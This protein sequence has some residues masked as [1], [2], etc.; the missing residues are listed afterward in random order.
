MFFDLLV[1]LEE[2]ELPYFEAEMLHRGQLCMAF[3]SRRIREI[4]EDGK[5]F[6][7]PSDAKKYFTKILSH[8]VAK[9][10]D[11]L[12]ERFEAPEDSVP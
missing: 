12:R 6:R 5:I 2:N 9:I 7:T 11:R 3:I 4:I 10:N 8:K 1:H